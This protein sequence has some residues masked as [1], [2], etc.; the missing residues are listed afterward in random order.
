MAIFDGTDEE[1]KSK[2]R[3]YVITGL[4]LVL[5]LSGG[6]WY[7]FRFYPE[8]RTVE[9]FLQT[10]IRGDLQAAYHMWQPNPSYTFQDFVEHDWGPRG[11]YGPVRSFH[12]EDIQSSGGRGGGVIVVVAVSAT[13]PF[14]ARD[15]S[16]KLREVKEVRLWVDR[17]TKA[18]RFA[19]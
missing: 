12:I 2:I 10:V 9:G 19:P 8:K 18:L 3:R 5:L 4:A 6:V 13:A 15:D 1:P 16:A 7:L 14:P 11:D 17:E